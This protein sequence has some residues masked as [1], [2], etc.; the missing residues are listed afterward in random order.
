ME[1]LTKKFDKNKLYIK[2][3][4]LTGIAFGGNKNR[5]LEYLL[6]DAIEKNADVVIT[7]GAVTSNHCRQT[8]GCAA[9]AG[10]DC[11][12]VLSDAHIGEEVNGN[13]LLNH[14]L[15]VDIQRVKTPEERKPKM[16]Q[17]AE[18]LKKKGRNP[19]IIPTGGSNKIGVLGYVNFVKEIAEQSK[20]MGVTFDY[21]VHPTGSAGTQ[22]GL[23]IGKKLY[24][25]ELE[26][27]AVTAGDG[28]DFIINEIKH[29]ISEFEKDHS[30]NLEIADEDIILHDHYFGEGY[31]I[32]NQKLIDTVKLVAKLEG[33]FLDPV[34][35]GKTMIGLLDLLEKDSFPKESNILFLH[36]GGG[37]AIFSYK[38]VFRK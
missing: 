2:R 26:I 14:I 38:D 9:R 21:F 35:N 6:A 15:D 4:D 32:P 27:I 10:L 17:I 23:L 7:E 16:K 31:G 1:R 8:A 36:S 25:P 24:Y 13:L 29:I 18:E 20:Q 11:I 3:D 5:K 30:L 28:K 12:L 19:Y 22:A 34:Y 37:P 33:L